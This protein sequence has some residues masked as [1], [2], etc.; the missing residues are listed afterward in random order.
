MSFS[1]TTDLPELSSESIADLQSAWE[2]RI[3]KGTVALT[4][5]NLTIAEADGRLTISDRRNRALSIR[6]ER[7][8][9]DNKGTPVVTVKGITNA[10]VHVAI[11][12]IMD[13]NSNPH[14]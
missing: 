11:G 1:R 4:R 14:W 7:G 5:D 9:P 2:S 10:Q 12:A 8:T 6:L 13:L 3:N